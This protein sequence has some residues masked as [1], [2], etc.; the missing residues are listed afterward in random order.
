MMSKN[1]RHVFI[2]VLLVLMA[3]LAVMLLQNVLGSGQTEI[4]RVSVLLDGEG[5]SY[6]PVSYTHLT[7]PTI[8]LV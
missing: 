8:L 6:W 2:G 3:A 7:L 4:R 5:E 1:E